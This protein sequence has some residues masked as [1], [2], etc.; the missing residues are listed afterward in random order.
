[1]LAVVGTVYIFRQNG[2]AGGKNFLQRYFAIG[3]VVGTRWL[4]TFAIVSVV[5]YGMLMAMNADIDIES[6]SWHGFLFV[7]VAE[8]AFYWRVGSHVRDIAKR[9][10][11][12]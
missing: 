10:K 2:G 3:W 12:A 11:S 1:M 9:E 7:A 5:F 8:T 6:T 4:V